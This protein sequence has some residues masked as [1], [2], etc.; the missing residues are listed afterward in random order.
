MKKTFL[1]IS[2]LSSKSYFCRHY[3]TF[4]E[5]AEGKKSSEITAF[6][7]YRGVKR[8]LEPIKLR[9]ISIMLRS[10]NYLV[11]SSVVNEF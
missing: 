1:I 11:L 8:F 9:E 5:L 7:I 10:R 6:E 3:F 2:T 4:E